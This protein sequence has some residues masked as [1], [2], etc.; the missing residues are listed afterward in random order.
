MSSF[1]PCPYLSDPLQHSDSNEVACTQV[2]SHGGKQCK[3]DSPQDSKAHQPLGSKAAGQVA[4]GDLCHNVTVEKRAQDPSLCLRV[5]VVHTGLWE[6][7]LEAALGID[8]IAWQSKQIIPELCSFTWA[9]LSHFSKTDKLLSVDLSLYSNNPA[10]RVLLSHR[11][12]T[13]IKIKSLQSQV[14][15][16]KWA[17]VWSSGSLN[18]KIISVPSVPYYCYTK[19][20]ELYTGNYTTR[21]KHTSTLHHYFSENQQNFRSKCF[22]VGLCSRSHN[23]AHRVVVFAYCRVG[24]RSAQGTAVVVSRLV[25]AV[26]HV[27]HRHAE[28]HPQGVDHKEAKRGKNS[29]GVAWWTACWSWGRVI[30]AIICLHMWTVDI[31]YR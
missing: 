13:R 6:D 22:T 20:M 21:G 12:Y 24:M 31:N 10:Y 4:P 27:H 23:R 25:G 8:I 9:F 5:P 30:T 19:Y 29:Q 3:N 7:E 17:L 11:Q 28:V 16:L 15:S 1:W 18:L 2:S 14:L 26:E